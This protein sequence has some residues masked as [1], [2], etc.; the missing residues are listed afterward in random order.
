MKRSF[1]EG[2]IAG[3]VAHEPITIKTMLSHSTDYR[4]GFV[5]G[6]AYALEKLC[7]NS[8]IS[9]Y[10]AGQ[11]AYRYQLDYEQLSDFFSDVTDNGPSNCFLDGYNNAKSFPSS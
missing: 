3:L 6:F 9:Q 1:S 11:L 2:L 8:T 7:N 5:C 10:R 4:K